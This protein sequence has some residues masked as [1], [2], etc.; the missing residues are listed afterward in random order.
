MLGH[1]A[2]Q[3]LDVDH[4]RWIT[5]GGMWFLVIRPKK[6]PAFK[7]AFAL[8]ACVASGSVQ[9]F[10][11]PQTNAGEQVHKHDGQYLD[12]HEWQ[13]AREDLVQ[14]DMWR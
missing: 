2:G 1:V 10:R 4:V 3:N 13:H 14:C 5:T 6:R 8:R 11:Q 9:H 12:T 7:P